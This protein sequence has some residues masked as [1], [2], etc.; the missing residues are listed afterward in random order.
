MIRAFRPI[1]LKDFR[2]VLRAGIRTNT[3]VVFLIAS[4]RNGTFVVL[5]VNQGVI[6]L[7]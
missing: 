6:K 3:F 1:I 7:R 5:T 2:I 4:I